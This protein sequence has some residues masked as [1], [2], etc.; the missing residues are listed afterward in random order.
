MVDEYQLTH[1]AYVRSSEGQKGGVSFGRDK[2]LRVNTPQPPGDSL[3]GKS[4]AENYYYCHGK[5][6]WKGS[7]PVLKSKSKPR[8][9]LCEA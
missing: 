4:D 6:H 1:R 8:F 3:I 7:C 2:S 9:F 5:G